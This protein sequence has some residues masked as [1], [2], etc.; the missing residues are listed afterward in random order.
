VTRQPF[1]QA[2]GVD[3]LCLERRTFDDAAVPDLPAALRVEDRA[4]QD[5][6][7][8]IAFRSATQATR[9]V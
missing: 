8:L 6:I 7:D 4:V 5:Q 9:P 2:P 1:D 3:D